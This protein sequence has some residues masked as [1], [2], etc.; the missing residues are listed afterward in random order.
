M[1][2]EPDEAS[3]TGALEDYIETV[4]ELVRDHKVARVRDIAR[5]RK[6]RSA[7]VTPAMR[8][9]ADLG[10]VRYVQREYIDLTPEGERF[11]RRVYARHQILVRFLQHVLGMPEGAAVQDACAME[12]S[13]SPVA[14]DHLV[15]FFEFLGYCPEGSS[16]LER[17]HACPMIRNEDGRCTADCP[18]RRD[19]PAGPEDWAVRLD[20]VSP[21][22]RVRIV[23]VEASGALRDRI[24]DMG[25]LPDVHGA[26]LR[27]GPGSD[28]FTLRVQGFDIELSPEEANAVLI[29]PVEEGS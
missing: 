17:F 27:G 18:A 8:R 22:C 19:A 25:I 10:L 21:E 13:L 1:M 28:R 29:V 4:Y 5:A 2:V 15:R 7:S 26:V 24:L 14:M 16:F 12:H 11:A 6:V 23:Q 20:S 3:L 9:L